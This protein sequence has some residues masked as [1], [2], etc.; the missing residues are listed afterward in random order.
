MI[1]LLTR[2]ESAERDRDG[3][4]PLLCPPFAGAIP[5]RETEEIAL[6]SDQ[7]FRM[8]RLL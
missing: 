4:S 3:G 1:P 6:P 7:I 5:R 8:R 2:T